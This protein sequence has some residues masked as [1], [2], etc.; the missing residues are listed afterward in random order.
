MHI[1]SIF[2]FNTVPI[3]IYIVWVRPFMYL[4]IAIAIYMY[5]GIDAR[6]IRKAYQANLASVISVVI[7]IATFIGLAFILGA[8]ENATA[9]TAA[10]R[11]WHLITIGS[12]V[13]LREIIRFKLIKQASLIERNIVITVLILTLVF[14]QFDYF[15]VLY[16]T[17]TI[18]PFRIFFAAMLPSLMVNIVASYIAIKGTFLSVILVSLVYSLGA[19]IMPILPHIEPLPWALVVSVLLFISVFIFRFAV[20][21]Q[22]RKAKRREARLSKYGKQP[23]FFNLATAGVIGLLIAFF[24]GAFP[25]YPVA[26]LTD[27]MTGT[28]N[29]GSLVFVH[30]VPEG[31][32]YERVGEGYIIHFRQGRMEFIHRTVGFEH[33]ADGRREYITQGDASYLV[34]PWRTTQDDVMG[35][36]VTFLPYIAWPYVIVRFLIGF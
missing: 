19:L 7:Y 20:Y 8:G 36:A 17:D 14:S 30:R 35:I 12:V 5:F 9:P 18:D 27:S 6:R 13:V 32:A 1:I 29:Q 22:T 28:F 34:D 31:Q 21:G 26:I 3:S 16:R 11:I 10:M 24:L 23:I 4:T 2:G 15:R 25:I 33:G